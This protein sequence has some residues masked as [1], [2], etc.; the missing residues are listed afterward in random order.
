MD[1]EQLY[2]TY[3]SLKERPD[4]PHGWIQW[5]GTDVCMDI[6]CKCG[7]STH[8]DVDRC[9]HVKCPNCGQVY[10]CSGFIKLTPLDFQP[11]FTH[12]PELPSF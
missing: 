1:T 9:Y 8:I 7:T 11:E 2:R 6:N 10:E 5:K 3:P 12:E 4:S